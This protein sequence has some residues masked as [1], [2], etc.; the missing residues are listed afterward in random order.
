MPE[1]TWDGKFDA[2]GRKVAP[3]RIALPFQ[4]ELLQ[5]AVAAAYASECQLFKER[6]HERSIVFHIARRLADTVEKQLPGW[7]VD[8]EYD[9]W[10]VDD[11][12][13]VKKRMRT[14]LLQITPADALSLIGADGDD[15]EL[16]DVYPDIIVHDRSGLGAE[17]DLLVVEVKKEETR[18]HAADIAKL[19]GFLARPFC[20]QHAVFVVLPKDGGMPR[21]VPIT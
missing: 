8:V 18:G 14:T 17:H 5:S 1:L 6:A 20:Y 3:P 13:D 4:T 7:F 15:D 10:H 19:R 12:D 16:K 2:A 9:R 21:C 11:L